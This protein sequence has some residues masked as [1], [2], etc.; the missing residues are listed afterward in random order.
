MAEALARRLAGDATATFAG[1]DG[2]AKLKLLGVEVASFGDPFAAGDEVRDVA[3]HDLVR[4]VYQ[5]VVVSA[6]GTAC[7]AAIL[8]GD[9]A[10]CPACRPACSGAALTC[11]PHAPGRRRA[12]APVTADA[13][14]CTC[15]DVSAVTCTAIRD[16]GLAP[17]TTSSTTRAAAAAAVAD[18]SG[19]CWRRAARRGA[20]VRNGLCEHFDYTRAELYRIVASL[21]LRD[22]TPSAALP[23][24]RLRGRKPVAASIRQ[25]AQ[26]DD[27]TATPRPDTNDR[28]SPTCSARPVLG[29][30]ARPRW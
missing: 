3:F 5:K 11:P 19:A 15:N 14:I 9:T 17:S 16:R 1:A 13:Q 26:R 10:P 7:S 29:G 27:P 23:R 25:R 22:W 20:T 24:R 18:R 21:G 12:A 30:A 4:G 2:A 8:V 28:F 6:D